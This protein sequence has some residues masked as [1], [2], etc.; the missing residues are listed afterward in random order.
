M[1]LQKCV[2]GAGRDKQNNGTEWKAQKQTYVYKG[3]WYM[4][5]RDT[6]K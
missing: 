1:N 2:I 3:T 5:G 4:D 6:Y